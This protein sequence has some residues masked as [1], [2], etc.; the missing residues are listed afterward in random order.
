[1]I[2]TSLSRCRSPHGERGLKLG[3]G[4][5]NVSAAPSLP[6]RGAWIEIDP[7]PGLGGVLVRRSPHGERGLKLP[8]RK[9]QSLV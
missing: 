8:G 9:V 1:M 7:L 5:S 6:S 4:N 2:P 3:Q